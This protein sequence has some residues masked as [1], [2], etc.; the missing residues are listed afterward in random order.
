MFER[1]RLWV[2]FVAEFIH[3]FFQLMYG[4]WRISKIPAPMISI[5]GGTYL[6]AGSHYFQMAHELGQ[7]LIEHNISVVTGGGP[8][9][10]EAASCGALHAGKGKGRIVGISV[11]DLNEPRNLCVQDYFVL[12]QFFA[13]KWL[14]THYSIAF[15]VFP[16]GFGTLDELS[17]VLTLTQTKN[18]GKVPVILFGVEFWQPFMEWVQDEAVGHGVVSGADLDLFTVT[19]NLDEVVQRVCTHC[20]HMGHK[21]K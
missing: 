15:V 17:E 6:P 12:D 3:V 7:R 19:D 11:R 16:G 10:M 20:T 8:G 4:A 14:L 13:R 9:I 5:F 1:M 2:S 18:L 21:I